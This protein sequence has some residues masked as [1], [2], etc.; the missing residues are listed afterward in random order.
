MTVIVVI[1]LLAAFVALVAALGHEIRIDG[2]GHR[3]PPRSRGDEAE[4]RWRQL[5]RLAG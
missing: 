5:G 2:Y 4:E 3:P 1:S